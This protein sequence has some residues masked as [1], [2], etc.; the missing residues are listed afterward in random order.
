MSNLKSLSN[1]HPYLN[2]RLLDICRAHEDT[3]TRKP[4]AVLVVYCR[5]MLSK[6]QVIAVT[7]LLARRFCLATFAS[8][9]ASRWRCKW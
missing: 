9:F 7:R 5:A 4:A 6:P 2:S 8:G 3:K 1:Q